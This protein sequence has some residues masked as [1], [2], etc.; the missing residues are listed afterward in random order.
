MFSVI[1]VRLLTG[2]GEKGPH[3]TITHNALDLTIQGP[4]T[5]P[6]LDT[7][8]GTRSLGAWPCPPPHGTDT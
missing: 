8:H 4:L 5:Y 3:V 1:F 6:R 7:S 2:E